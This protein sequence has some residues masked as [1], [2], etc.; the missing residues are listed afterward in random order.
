M[1]FLR[2]EEISNVASPSKGV[3]LLK[4]ARILLFASTIDSPIG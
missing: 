1:L 2:I 3:A 4:F